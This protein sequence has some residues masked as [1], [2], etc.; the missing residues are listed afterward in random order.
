MTVVLFFWLLKSNPI[1]LQTQE[2]NSRQ[3]CVKAAKALQ[4]EFGKDFRFMCVDK[5]KTK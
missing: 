1:L 4:A 5:G 3:A 2:F